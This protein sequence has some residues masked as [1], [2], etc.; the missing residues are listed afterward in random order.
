MQ[1]HLNDNLNAAK[2]KTFTSKTAAFMTNVAANAKKE[3]NMVSFLNLTDGN[4]EVGDLSTIDPALFRSAHEVL[5]PSLLRKLGLR[6]DFDG[7]RSMVPN[8]AAPD[9][10]R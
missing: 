10:D 2:W 7:Y 3:L 1:I 9:A 8:V 5:P 6:G 4:D